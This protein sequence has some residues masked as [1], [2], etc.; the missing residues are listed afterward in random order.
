MT[1]RHRLRFATAFAAFA[2][3]APPARAED[4]TVQI[5][6]FMFAPMDLQVAAGTTVVWKN[7]DEEP[8][9]VT[10]TTGLFRSGGIDGGGT[11]RFTFASAGVY[12]YVCSIHP[13][14]TG[15]VTVR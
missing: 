9:T 8:H 12:H 3:A 6:N 11:Y 14:M 10:S 2:L 15:T 7:L 5:R 1:T 4:A 13:Q